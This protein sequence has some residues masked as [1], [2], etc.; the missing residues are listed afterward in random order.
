MR[1]YTILLGL[2]AVFL[3]NTA[4][5]GGVA[6]EPGQWEMTSTMTMSMM[7]QPQTTTVL[8]CIEE[9]ELDPESFNMDE[10]T[11]CDI[12]DVT[13][14]GNTARWS[15][16]CPTEGG[17]VMEGHWEV[18]SNGDSLTGKGEMTTE[19]AGQKMG[20]NMNWQGKRIGKCE[21]DG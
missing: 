13:T 8:E 14:D 20:F 1:L 11:P 5:A 19:M 18:T 9:D 4:N 12:T 2:T 15:I 21:K 6:I 10:D 7:P 3:V 17:A 16:N